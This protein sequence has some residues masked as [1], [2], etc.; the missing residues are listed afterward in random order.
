MY[1][2]DREARADA[3][4]EEL[5]ERAREGDDLSYYH[6]NASGDA[7]R[8]VHSVMATYEIECDVNHSKVP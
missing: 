2:D 3:F 8:I 6:E 5:H 7:L 4:A 1:D